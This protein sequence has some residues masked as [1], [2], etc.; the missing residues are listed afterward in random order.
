MCM[1]CA[2]VDLCCCGSGIG[3]GVY[4]GVGTEGYCAG[5]SGAGCFGGWA[6]LHHAAGEGQGRLGGMHRYGRTQPLQL[7]V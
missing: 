3:G 7:P 2:V 1:R 4:V 6:G 5:G